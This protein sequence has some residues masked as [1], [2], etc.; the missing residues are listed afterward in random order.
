MDEA[1]FIREGR[2]KHQDALTAF[3]NVSYAHQAL[4]CALTVA[5]HAWQPL[6]SAQAFLSV[7]FV[8]IN[9][10][11][12]SWFDYASIDELHDGDYAGFGAA[13]EN[14]SI[15]VQVHVFD[16]VVLLWGEAAQAHRVDHHGRTRLFDVEYENHAF[17]RGDVE[18]LK[19]RIYC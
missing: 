5:W 17:S 11:D 15:G 7:S 14:I 3:F 6:E 4:L 8:A 18:S 9:S 2:L 1:Y 13:E 12:Y 10:L 16:V 19:V